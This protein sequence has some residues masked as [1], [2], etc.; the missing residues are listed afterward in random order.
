MS[1]AGCSGSGNTRLQ[2]GVLI[3]ALDIANFTPLDDFYDHVDGLVAHVKASPTAP[4]F[5][6]ILTPGEIEA[7]QT[8]R[9]LHEGIPTDN[10]TWR[11]IQ[12][13]AAGVGISEL[14]F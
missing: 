2:K 14:E 3:I 5:D 13:T 12:E 9:R 8:K 10:E 7:R 1:G 4:G 11:Q 6:E